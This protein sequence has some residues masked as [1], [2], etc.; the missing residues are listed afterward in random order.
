MSKALLLALLLGLAWTSLAEQEVNAPAAKP[1]AV[2]TAKAAPKAA[3]PKAA[4]PKAATPA[5]PKGK[6]HVKA[7]P[8]KGKHHKGKGKHHHKGK[9]KHH[10]GKG[11]HH[12]KGKGKHHKKC[13]KGRAG[14]NCRRKR[15]CVRRHKACEKHCHVT[16][17]TPHTKKL[18]N[19][20]CY[21][22]AKH[23][24]CNSC[25]TPKCRAQRKHCFK[26]LKT[27]QFK[28]KGSDLACMK[29]CRCSF[30][31][32]K[33]H[34]AKPVVAKPH[35]A[36]PVAKVVPHKAPAKHHVKITPPKK[37][38]QCPCSHKVR[39]CA[40]VKKCT[41]R[42]TTP[43]STCVQKER[44]E[45]VLCQCARHD[46]QGKCVEKKMHMVCVQHK[47]IG[48]NPTGECLKQE[49]RCVPQ[50]KAKVC[51]ARKNK[52]CIKHSCVKPAVKTHFKCLKKE[53][54]PDHRC[55]KAGYSHKCHWKCAARSCNKATTPVIEHPLD[56]KKMAKKPAQEEVKILDSKGKEYTTAQLKAMQEHD[57]KAFD[58]IVE[59][60]HK[61]ENKVTDPAQAYEIKEAEDKIEGK[62]MPKAP[63]AAIKTAKV[64][65]KAAAAPAKKAAAAPAKKAAA[66]PAKKAAAA[67]AKKAAAAPAKKA[68]SH[69]AV[70][71]AAAAHVSAPVVKK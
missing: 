42:N 60:L 33:L 37:V 48:T 3:A 52:K 5:T 29:K 56:H 32:A 31:A 30:K 55:L 49:V 28:C 70:A 47:M 20:I 11:K 61:A 71:H 41:L 62:P 40:A 39:S 36:K 24:A 35:V 15:R 38:H 19:D 7:A 64:T 67:P 59:A 54:V 51:V 68:A 12:H 57:K 44:T 53:M 6:G 43:K 17:K 34:V 16:T 2:K 50:C 25:H 63:K 4:A 14:Y 23:R 21:K 26:Q 18:C 8:K 1:E 27:C 22:H 45:V 69:P 10:K 13:K 58:A 65:K 66:A 46:A 9:G